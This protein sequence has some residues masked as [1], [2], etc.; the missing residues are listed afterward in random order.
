MNIIAALTKTGTGNLKKWFRNTEGLKCSCTRSINDHDN[1]ISFAK[2]AVCGFCQG[3]LPLLV[4]N[5]NIIYF[6]VPN[7]FAFEPLRL[8][9]SKG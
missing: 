7:I 2:L 1:S 5:E 4:K 9:T 6:Y 8:N 3:F